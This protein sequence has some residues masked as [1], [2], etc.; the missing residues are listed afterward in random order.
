[1]G[2]VHDVDCT[3]E[4]TDVAPRASALAGKGVLVTGA[5]RGLGR[6]LAMY[7]AS[8]GADLAIV[9]PKGRPGA[10]ET[11]QLIA[12]KGWR[13][14]CFVMDLAD[15]RSCRLVVRAAVAGLGR[16][17][18]LVNNAVEQLTDGN[19]ETLDGAELERVFK[20]HVFS[21][22]HLM[23]AAV[24]CMTEGG[25][26]VNTSSIT[27][28]GRPGSSDDAVVSLACSLAGHLAR[29]KIQVKSEPYFVD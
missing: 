7:Y 16:L 19:P 22:L 4:R 12:A 27:S 5:N 13:C 29:R 23:A 11:M 10:L 24:E 26:I 20:H 15:A 28:V 6:E 1:M 2:A 25:R 14:L 8:N 3:Q 17:D 9:C 18:V 21:Y